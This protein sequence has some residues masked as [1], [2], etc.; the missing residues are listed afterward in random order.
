MSC[1]VAQRGTSGLY[2]ESSVLLRLTSLHIMPFIPIQPQNDFA[3][4]DTIEEKR[5]TLNGSLIINCCRSCYV[6]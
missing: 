3:I 1:S 2:S 5:F 4:G 6:P